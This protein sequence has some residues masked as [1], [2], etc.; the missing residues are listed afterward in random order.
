MERVSKAVAH[1]IPIRLD[2]PDADKYSE[3]DVTSKCPLPSCNEVMPLKQMK[4][5]FLQH[6]DCFEICPGCGY[7]FVN[8]HAFFVHVKDCLKDA[9]E[10][11]KAHSRR[12]QRALVH[13][14]VMRLQEAMDEFE[15]GPV[16]A[17]QDGIAASLPGQYQPPRTGFSGDPSLHP[18]LS[19]DPSAQRHVRGTGPVYPASRDTRHLDQILGLTDP[20]TDTQQQRWRPPGLPPCAFS[21]APSTAPLK[22]ILPPLS[23]PI[24]DPRPVEAPC[25]AESP[26]PV[27]TPRLAEASPQAPSNMMLPLDLEMDNVMLPMDWEMDDF[28][29]SWPPEPSFEHNPN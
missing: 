15:S 17:R 29:D 2:P 25:P 6:V 1:L 5:H 22:P 9:N 11:K 21:Q 18:L 4:Y 13:R 10:I 26:C 24:E 27:E 16:E 23:R 7:S 14:T 19:R 3:S 12:R 8:V 20:A 28:M